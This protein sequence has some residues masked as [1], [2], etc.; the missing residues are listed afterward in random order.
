M[1]QVQVLPAAQTFGNQF[2]GVLGGALGSIGQ[3]LVQGHLNRQT[4]KKDDE[5]LQDLAA[6]PNASPLE[7]I[8]KF[9][10]LSADKRKGLE[11][12]FGDYLK[13]QNTNQAKAAETEAA[14]A[15]MKDTVKYLKENVKYT[16]LTG[17]TSP[18]KTFA[19]RKGFDSS[20]FL[21]ADYV[22][23][24]FNKGQISNA[25][26]ELIKKDIAPRSDLTQLENKARIDSLERIMALPSSAPKEQVDRII[27][28][29]AKKAKGANKRLPLADFRGGAL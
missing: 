19:A 2:G 5:I 24:H 25:K 7:M 21:A 17:E 9:G 28:E 11:G 15:G 27:D 1:P 6:N 18:D 22:Y 14:T 16:G 13:T 4:N 3:G 8:Q 20:G 23:T 12:L 10:K 29:E 26:L